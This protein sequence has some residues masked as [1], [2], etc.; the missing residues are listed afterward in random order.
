M[1]V[2]GVCIDV[3][4]SGLRIKIGVHLGLGDLVGILALDADGNTVFSGDATVVWADIDGPPYQTGLQFGPLSEASRAVI[5]EITGGGERPPEPPPVRLDD[6]DVP[7]PDIDDV[8][9]ESLAPGPE[10]PSSPA[11][12]APE[13]PAPSEP[14][15]PAPE[16][17][18]AEPPAPAPETPA[19]ELSAAE[20]QPSLSDLSKL[21]FETEQKALETAKERDE[22]PAA[23]GVRSLSPDQ[24]TALQMA[25]EQREAMDDLAAARTKPPPPE[26]D[27]QS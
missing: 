8:L 17:S 14:G 9:P 2:Q 26:D 6:D 23:A 5:Q 15:P 27:S 1:M 13:A 24:L 7:L 18:A 21:F 11:A 22:N 16:A 20:Q 25:G 4:E 3:S 19:T 10:P 12:A